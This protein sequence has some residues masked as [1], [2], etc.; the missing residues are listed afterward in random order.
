MTR[1]KPARTAPHGANDGCHGAARDVGFAVTAACERMAGCWPCSVAGTTAAA[2]T[3][4]LPLRTSAAMTP[5]PATNAAATNSPAATRPRTST[6]P[7]TATSAMSDR[8]P[9]RGLSRPALEPTSGRSRTETP[10]RSLDACVTVA[11]RQS[12]V[13]VGPRMST[14]A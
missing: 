1:T 10:P 2:C 11:I 5:A 14:Q 6:T 9:W 3:G 4:G 8:A 12:S 7:T 13:T